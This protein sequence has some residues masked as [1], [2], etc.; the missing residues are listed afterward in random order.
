MH[1]AYH[2]AS[3]QFTMDG[4]ITLNVVK[5]SNTA[6]FITNLTAYYFSYIKK[7]Y[8]FSLQVI[9]VLLSLSIYAILTSLK[10]QSLTNSLNLE[11]S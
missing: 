11:I 2:L 9:T 7:A 5:F 1:L 10:G 4:T 6:N 8:I 3:I